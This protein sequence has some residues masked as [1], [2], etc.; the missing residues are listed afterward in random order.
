M[1]KITKT[2]FALLALAPTALMFTACGQGTPIEQGPALEALNAAASVE[3][4][5]A[6]THDYVLRMEDNQ[7]TN[8]DGVSQ[9]INTSGTIRVSKSEDN[10][11][12]DINVS[13]TM[14]ATASGLVEAT[15]SASMSQ[16]YVIGTIDGQS[17]AVNTGKKLY[18]STDTTNYVN[19]YASLGSMVYVVQEAE[20]AGEGVTMELFETGENS[21]SLRFVI[22][23]E[24]T[25]TVAEETITT[26]TTTTYEYTITDGKLTY[27]YA[28]ELVTENGTRTSEA[29]CR[30]N[31]DYQTVAVPS[32]P[33]SL[34]GYEEGDMSMGY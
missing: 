15:Q 19:L 7:Y 5:S 12:Y 32:F 2:L 27:H 24:E 29:T 28:H 1:K 22:T 18:S 31:I 3:T 14:N 4:L 30:M 8:E 34:E 6:V 11:Y 10:F 26:V 21:Y 33:T 23:E 9:N 25:Q 17:Y 13:M 20:L 16:S